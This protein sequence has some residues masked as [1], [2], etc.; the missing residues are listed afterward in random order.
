[1][2]CPTIFGIG[3]PKSGSHS[4]WVALQHCG[5]RSIHTGNYASPDGPVTPPDFMSRL[6]DY[7]FNLNPDTTG[8]ADFLAPFPE[9]KNVQGLLDYPIYEY[10]EKIDRVV[11]DAKFIMTYRPPDDCAFSWCRMIAHFSGPHLHDLGDLGTYIGFLDTAR[12]VYN[13]NLAYFRSK[14]EKLLFIDS[15]VPGN[16]NTKLLRKF[17]GLPFG[18]ECRNWPCVFGHKEWYVEK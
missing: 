3:P 14:P 18:E 1:M 12:R 9:L 13:D 8:P 16:E 2:T 10:A 17:L 6:N 5:V 4:L 11:P 7:F 15:R